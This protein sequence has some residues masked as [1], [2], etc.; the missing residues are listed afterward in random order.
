M[1]NQA[2][3]VAVTN[4]RKMLKKWTTTIP[5]QKKM[6]PKPSRMGRMRKYRIHL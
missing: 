1:E 6:R 3:A 2:I 4:P 5:D